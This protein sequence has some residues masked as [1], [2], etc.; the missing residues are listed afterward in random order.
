MWRLFSTPLT[1]VKLPA[2]GVQ[3]GQVLPSAVMP[4]TSMS[5]LPIM[6]STCV[7][8]VLIRPPS[9]SPTANAKPLPRAIW[10]AAFSA[11]SVS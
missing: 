9:S 10:L 5:S 8:L 7:E 4:V 2:A 3:D 1:H 6:K 11:R